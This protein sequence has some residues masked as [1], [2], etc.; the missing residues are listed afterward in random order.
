MRAVS[1]VPRRGLVSM[2]V[3]ARRGESVEQRRCHVCARVDL[4]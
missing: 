2:E 3:R 1:L 4:V